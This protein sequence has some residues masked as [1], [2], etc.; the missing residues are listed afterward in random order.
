MPFPFMALGAGISG[1]GSL[2]KIFAGAKQN[3]LANQINPVFQQY[4]QN[5]LAQ[6]N[7]AV[8]KNM[9]YGADPASLKAQSNVMQAQSNQLASAQRG[10]TDASQLLAVGA[11][12]QGGTNEAFSNLAAAEGQSKAGLLTN[13]GQAYRGA[14]SEGD[15]A[16]ESMLQKY[17][18]DSQA[19]AALR[20]AG[21]QNIFGGIG[22]VAGGLM[23]YGM[24]KGMG[25]GAGMGTQSTQGYPLINSNPA[26]TQNI[27]F[28]TGN[29]M[30]GLKMSPYQV[31]QSAQSF[32]Y[33]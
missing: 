31:P 15:K 30:G 9:F 8:N 6:E 28:G 33:P 17:Q 32:K 13:L 2:G 20:N 10:A 3:K 27:L 12:L 5:P 21:Q 24:F 18:M 1:L 23:Q 22:D 16:Y 19:K 25:S 29:R 11:G 7:L 4:Q 26:L 14:I